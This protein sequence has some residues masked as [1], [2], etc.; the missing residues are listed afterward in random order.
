VVK[1]CSSETRG[2]S[3][4][5]GDTFIREESASLVE[6]IERDEWNNQ[7]KATTRRM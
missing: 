2:L 4:S 1:G 5:R 3:N 7:S 6:A